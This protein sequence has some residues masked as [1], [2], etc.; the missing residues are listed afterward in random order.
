MGL[1][2]LDTNCGPDVVGLDAG[3]PARVI[4]LGHL[5]LIPTQIGLNLRDVVEKRRQQVAVARR[6]VADQLEKRRRLIEV[7]ALLDL[8]VE[9]LGDEVPEASRLLRKARVE[10]VRHHQ[11]AGVQVPF[12]APHEAVAPVGV[13]G[14]AHVNARGSVAI[15]AL[16]L[17]KVGGD[18]LTFLVRAG[19][20]LGAPLVLLVGNYIGRVA[21]VDIGEEVE[22]KRVRHQV[23]ASQC[24]VCEPLAVQSFIDLVDGLLKRHMLEKRCGVEHRGRPFE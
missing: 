2:Q 7:A 11:G 22:R 19:D 21:V 17:A 12:R 5:L 16:V 6:A 8:G 9:N 13:E 18:E 10:V 4:G 15:D 14:V 24:R 20:T 1:V 3:I 23:V